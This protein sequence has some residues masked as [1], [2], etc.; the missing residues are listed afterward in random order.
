MSLFEN[1]YA[2]CHYAECRCAA[3]KAIANLR[4]T[5][6]GA[7][8]KYETRVK[9]S[10]TDKLSSLVHKLKSLLTLLSRSINCFIAECHIFKNYCA[11]CH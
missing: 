3:W 10:F 6:C 7:L 8:L 4:G 11:E 2:E 9:V 1:Y 5:L